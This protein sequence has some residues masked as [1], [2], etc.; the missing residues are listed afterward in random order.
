MTTPDDNLDDSQ[1]DNP[2]LQP[3]MKT[4]DGNLK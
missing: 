4:P 3:Q 1:D 2:R